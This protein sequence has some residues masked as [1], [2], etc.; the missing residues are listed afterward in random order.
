MTKYLFILSVF[1]LSACSSESDVEIIEGGL[2]CKEIYLSKNDQR[3]TNE[4]M[5]GETAH[6]NFSDIKGLTVDD[7]G[8][9]TTDIM[10]LFLNKNGDTVNFSPYGALDQQEFSNGNDPVIDF[11]LFTNITPPLFHGEEYTWISG[12]KEVSTG[13]TIEGKTTL[14]VLENTDIIVSSEGFSYKEVYLYDQTTDG[15]ITNQKIGISNEN[16][17]ILQGIDGFDLIDGNALLGVSLELTDENN[18][19]LLKIDDLAANL[20]NGLLYEELEAALVVDFTVGNENI[21]STVQVDIEIWDKNGDA[22]MT[23]STLLDVE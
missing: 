1:F 12:F 7:N 18:K 19:S 23:I 11:N 14:K 6:M 9:I 21:T 15:Y 3:F 10:F 22:K 13:K 5:F 4:I 16:E 8:T 20:P 2:N 17:L